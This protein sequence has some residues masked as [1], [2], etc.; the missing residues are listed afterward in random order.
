MHQHVE[1]GEQQMRL[2]A[3][4]LMVQPLPL[5]GRVRRLV[6]LEL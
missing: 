5:P 3:Q 1:P 6:S 4:D 2:V